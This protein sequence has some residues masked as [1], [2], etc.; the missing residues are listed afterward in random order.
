MQTLNAI[1]KA[2]LFLLV[3]LM[4]VPPLLVCRICSKT[5]AAAVIKL[6]HRMAGWAIG[7]KVTLTGEKVDHAAQLYVANH[8]SYLDI[9]A[10]GS[11]L[12]AHFIAKAEIAHWPFI[13]KMAAWAGTIFI[14][15]RRSHAR[16][17]VA[18][19]DQYL[20]RG[21][22]IVF[23]PEGT[24]TNG[25]QV[26]AFKPS[27]FEPYLKHPD[28]I[29]VQPMALAYFNAQTGK[30]LSDEEVITVAWLGDQDFFRHL[31]HFLKQPDV[32]VL[33]HV[34]P[35]VNTMAF[36]DR[37]S[38]AHHLGRDVRDTLKILLSTS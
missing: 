12:H 21:D 14:H 29:L 10:L 18:T 36:S 15:K 5:H 38:L 23:F 11:Q 3:T 28:T 2:S 8:C 27:L 26:E 6:W 19:L 32:R 33:I 22:R 25:R 1:R 20:D 34:L 24:S 16:H 13:G 7:L 37:K 30:P 4:L 35:V 17:H 9:L 31:W